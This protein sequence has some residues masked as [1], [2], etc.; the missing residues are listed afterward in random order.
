M[1]QT[2]QDRRNQVEPMRLQKWNELSAEWED[3]DLSTIGGIAFQNGWEGTTAERV[4]YFSVSGLFGRSL[5]LSDRG[6]VAWNDTDLGYTVLYDINGVW[7]RARDGESDNT[8]ILFKEAGDGSYGAFFLYVA[9]ASCVALSTVETQ[10]SVEAA[11]LEF[12]GFEAGTRKVVVSME[13]VTDAS[14]CT[15]FAFVCAGASDHTD[16]ATKMTILALST[17]TGTG[18]DGE[19][20]VLDTTT[21]GTVSRF[22]PQFVYEVADDETAIDRV[23]ILPIVNGASTGIVLFKIE[24]FTRA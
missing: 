19:F 7:R 11:I 2:N 3:I 8:A 16:A 10:A 15:A 14:P 13:Y 1:S 24:G 9:A 5:T 21:M 17:R 22:S 20:E 4:A 18:T 23:S 6:H 12:T